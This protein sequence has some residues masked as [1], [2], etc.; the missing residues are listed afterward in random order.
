MIF[1]LENVCLCIGSA[2]GI[3]WVLDNKAVVLE[4]DYGKSSFLWLQEKGL[5]KGTPQVTFWDLSFFVN[6]GGS[7]LVFYELSFVLEPVGTSYK[8]Q[9]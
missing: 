9:Q 8:V 7:Y 1:E 5:W 2:G 4:S 6:R 3:Q